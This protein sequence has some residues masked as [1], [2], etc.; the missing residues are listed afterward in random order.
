MPTDLSFE[1][2]HG[3]AVVQLVPLGLEAEADAQSILRDE[4]VQP[5]FSTLDE[6]SNSWAT[7]THVLQAKDQGYLDRVLRP[8]FDRPNPAFMVRF[9]IRAGDQTR[10]RPWS[11][12]I[13][14]KFDAEASP[15]EKSGPVVTLTTVDELWALRK[16][17][18]LRAHRGRISDIIQKIWAEYSDQPAVVEPT[19]LPQLTDESGRYY[20]PYESD[21]DFTL[22]QLLPVAASESGVSGYRL[23]MRDRRLHCCTSTKPPG[24]AVRLKYSEGVGGV[25]GLTL[26][27]R[28]VEL[29]AT[30]GTGRVTLVR[31]PLRGTDVVIESDSAVLSKLAAGRRPER[32]VSYTSAHVGLNLESEIRTKAQQ[33][34][35]VLKSESYR[36]Q[37]TAVN[38]LALRVG[39]LLELQITQLERRLS[40]FSGL[41]LV[42]TASHTIKE[43]ALSTVFVLVRGEYRQ[44]AQAA[45]QESDNVAQPEAT[46]V[47]P[48]LLGQPSGTPVQDAV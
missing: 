10:W 9:G 46:G 40:A 16:E 13:G 3:R 37:F 34:H 31:D 25:T 18:K 11:K 5:L 14:L 39:D 2:P 12:H 43:G 1:S 8:L 4:L 19:A 24:E 47:E 38:C 17:Q 7:H 27:D 29:S 26:T 30:G 48:Q 33:Q 42:A 6:P 21:Y 32:N 41:W 22:N 23:F 28:W 20:Q 36:A 35:E 15:D 45:V 44:S